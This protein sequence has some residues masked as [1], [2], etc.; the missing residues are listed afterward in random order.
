[1]FFIILFEYKEVSPKIPKT[2]IGILKNCY[3][4]HGFENAFLTTLVFGQD[5]GITA[6]VTSQLKYLSHYCM[7]KICCPFVFSWHTINQ[8][9]LRGHIVY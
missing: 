8:T 1:M 7:S 4:I 2:L 6:Q 5:S 9:R 3:R